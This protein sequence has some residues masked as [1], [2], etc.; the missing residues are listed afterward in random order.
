MFRD[1][2]DALALLDRALGEIERQLAQSTRS[3]AA[4]SDE[5]TQQTD[6]LNAEKRR[7]DNLRRQILQRGVNE[8][9]RQL[10]SEGSLD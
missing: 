4:T 8:L 5:W 7:I 9:E 6:R 2:R 3:K 1:T 10:E